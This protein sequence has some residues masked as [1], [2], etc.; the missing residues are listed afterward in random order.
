MWKDAIKVVLREVRYEGVD[1]ELAEDKVEGGLL[2]R[3]I[4]FRIPQRRGLS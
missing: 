4:T 2:K 3:G 1:C